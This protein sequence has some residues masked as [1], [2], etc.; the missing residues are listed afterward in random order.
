L[1]ECERERRAQRLHAQYVFREV[2]YLLRRLALD[3]I[4][5]T[6]LAAFDFVTAGLA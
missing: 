1:V 3:G 5:K 2:V 4:G 6:D